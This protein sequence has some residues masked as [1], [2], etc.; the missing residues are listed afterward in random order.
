M[1]ADLFLRVFTSRA[2]AENDEEVKTITDAENQISNDYFKPFRLETPTV[3][4]SG[5]AETGGP[6][7]RGDKEIAS[8]M[9][10]VVHVIVPGA[11]HTPTALLRTSFSPSSPS[12]LELSNPKPVVAVLFPDKMAEFGVSNRREPAR[13]CR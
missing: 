6:N 11:G 2:C 9:P 5:E 1:D 12:T 13:E 7:G 3:L 8:Y 4:V 10:N